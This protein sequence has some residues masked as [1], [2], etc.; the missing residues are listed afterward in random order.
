MA[1]ITYVADNIH[2]QKC[3]ATILNSLS[4]EF[5]DIE[6]RLD[7]EPKEVAVTLANKEQEE[8]FKSQMEEIGFPVIKE[9][10]RS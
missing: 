8:S 4:D 5:E 7:T 2:C 3:A 1:K 6:V 9:L 10:E